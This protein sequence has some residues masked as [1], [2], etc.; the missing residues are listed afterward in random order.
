[1]IWVTS[2]NRSLTLC[3]D[4]L[5]NIARHNDDLNAFI[6][7][8]PDEAR[9]Q[10]EIADA[11]A[12]RGE[13]LG[14][15]HGMPLA[16]KDNIDT[17]GTIT[18]SGAEPWRN[19][20]PDEDAMVVRRLKAAGAVLL[21]KTTLG[22][23]VFDV[24]SKN[25]IVGTARNPWDFERSPGGSS[26]GSAAA[27]AAGMAVGA[28]GS[29]TG[30]SVR[31]PA[32]HSGVVGL[33]PTHGA[34]SNRGVTAVSFQN[35]TIGPMAKR[36][37]DVARI[38]AAIE[39]YDSG[40]PYS[41]HHAYTNFLGELGDGVKGLRI[42]IPQNFFFDDVQAEITAAVMSVADALVDQGARL[43]KL[44]L[45]DAERTHLQTSVLIYSDVAAYH[46]TL[47][48]TPDQMTAPMYERLRRG[49]DITAVDY[50]RALDFKAR[51]RRTLALA[52]EDIDLLLTPT[53]PV[54]A[55]SNSDNEDLHS[56][57]ARVA[58]F[59]YA[60]TLASIPGLSL[61]CGFTANGL[62]IG[63]LLQAGWWNEPLLFRA[64]IAYQSVTDWHLRTPAALKC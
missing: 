51:W 55:L 22:E 43:V 8:T 47:L 19:H 18:T 53:T 3:N 13:W 30:G 36:V 33:R 31:L 40:D 42:G 27:V 45:P 4:C 32:A 54:E 46:R 57:T 61:P 10:A 23:L 52:F 20:V 25:P 38:F 64:G 21:G 15:L 63:A 29:D 49:L 62:P 48:E 16:L 9:K 37:T 1:M 7:I 28:L 59:T 11:A 41:R 17:A 6:T 34:V 60:G 26:G 12:A 44:T 2:L 14:L 24:R 56:A 58:Q 39:G 35:D 50:A 5:D